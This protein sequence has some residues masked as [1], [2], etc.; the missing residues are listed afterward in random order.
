MLDIRRETMADHIKVNADHHASTII[1]RIVAVAQEHPEAVAVVRG[2]ERLTY[3]QLQVRSNKVAHLI[4]ARGIGKGDLVGIAIER[5]IDLVV[6]IM[7]VLKTG[8][9][10]VAIDPDYPE[11]R[12]AQ[13]CSAVPLAL[14]LTT[15]GGL[16]N[17]PPFGAPRLHLDRDRP[18]IDAG[19][20]EFPLPEL[21]PDDLVY[22]V[23][24]SGSTG[25]PKA[26]AVHQA[27]WM[28]LMDWFTTRFDIKAS[29]RNLI[30]SSFSFDITQ[31]AIV[32]PLIMG[33]QLH[34][35]D[36]HSFDHELILSTIRGSAITLMNCAPSTFYPILEKG[37]D[38]SCL[39]SLRCLFL[40][41]EAINAARIRAWAEHPGTHAE[42]VNVYGAAE[43]SDVSTFHVLRDYARYVIDGVPAGKPIPGTTITLVDQAL[44]PVGA[45]DAGEILISG[46]GVGK[47][48][49]ND[50]DLT[51]RR[52]VKW[53]AG[54][55]STAYLTGDLGRWTKSDGLIF[56]G[57]ADNQV[58]VRGNRI[59]L[60]DV[61]SLLRQDVRIRDAVA[62]KRTLADGSEILAAFVI[63][64]PGTAVGETFA[65]EIRKAMGRRAP[66][67]MIPSLIEVVESFPLNPNGKVDRAAIAKQPITGAAPATANGAMSPAERAISEIFGHI[68]NVESAPRDANFFDL[69]GYSALVTEALAEIN[70]RF[71]SAI[72]IYEFLA[73]PTVEALAAR[74]RE[75]QST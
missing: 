59:D 23:Y 46:I 50:P 20:T 61:E 64:Q 55:R 45:D 19:P 22:V 17:R 62:G 75:P 4:A 52:F 53:P 32:M 16:G 39:G 10:Y 54:S 26:T 70:H 73:G 42:I 48:Y 66:P 11:E 34:L 68:L 41:G 12:V 18:R 27:G 13:M 7:A 38:L 51:S 47:G 33:G 72:T 1:E 14:L 40:G 5:S 67:F 74:I 44:E 2:A 21:L 31:R 60:G 36:G 9:A 29:D 56:V 63:A 24:T 69:G 30:V 57:R 43:C 37:S 8:A 65:T 25:V 35:L 15:E 71:D 49:I 3:R 58:K 28:N 6:A